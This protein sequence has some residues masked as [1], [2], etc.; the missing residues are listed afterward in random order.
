MQQKGSIYVLQAHHITY[1]S[2]AEGFLKLCCG[3]QFYKDLLLV[4][5]FRVV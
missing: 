1:S 3:Q 2:K 4:I 5:E